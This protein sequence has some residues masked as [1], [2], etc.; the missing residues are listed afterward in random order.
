[1]AS[2]PDG[3]IAGVAGVI[4]VCSAGGCDRPAVRHFEL[5]TT[6]GP[7]VGVVCERCALATSLAAFLLTL[8]A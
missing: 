6:H 7:L 3:R 2:K 5:V 4:G 1:M 8:L